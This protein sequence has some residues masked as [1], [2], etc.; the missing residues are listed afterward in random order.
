MPFRDPVLTGLVE[1]ENHLAMTKRV[2]R[3]SQISATRRDQ[4]PTRRFLLFHS[5]AELWIGDSFNENHKSVL[6]GSGRNRG[7][8]HVAGFIGFAREELKIDA[9]GSSGLQIEATDSNPVLQFVEKL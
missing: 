8:I 7:E 6:E 3:M 1:R 9:S 5:P 2:V 4:T